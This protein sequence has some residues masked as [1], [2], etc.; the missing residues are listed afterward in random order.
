[1][2]ETIKT[3]KEIADYLISKDKKMIKVIADDIV[4]ERE[5]ESDYFLSLV[6]TIISQQISSKVADVICKR[7]SVLCKDKVT[8]AA[9]NK[10]SDQQLRDIGISSFKAS[11][12]RSLVEAIDSKVVD[13]KHMENLSNEQVIEML[14]KIKGI[15][16]WSAEMFLIFC[17]G[18][19]D[20]FSIL[21]GALVRA[22]SHYYFKDQP[23]NKE[24]L[25]KL[26]KK[27]VPYRT[28]ASIYL[29]NSL[30]RF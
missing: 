9:I 11:Y 1:M 16:V 29:W 4:V 24:Q 18:R 10:L 12:I 17:L 7:I 5:K 3:N 25:L 14:I 19:E 26:S 23:V 22:V 27:W 20:V 2:K 21:D 6:Q 28:Y 30:K 15:G 8:P 13:L